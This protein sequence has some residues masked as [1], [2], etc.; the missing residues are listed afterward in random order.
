MPPGQGWS[1]DPWTPR[2]EGERLTGLGA[3]D[4]KGCVTAMIEAFLAVHRELKQGG[5]LGGTLV[6]ALTAQEETTG[7]G[8]PV[9]LDRL[10]PLDAAIVGEP[11]GLVPMTAQRGL[12]I[13]RGKAR[14]RTAHPA[15]TPPQVAENA[16]VAAAEDV[17][18]L[19][20]FDWGPAHPRLGRAHGNVTII[21]AGI[22]HNVIPDA[23]EFCLDIRTTPA[24]SHPALF[25]RLQAH[26]RSELSIQSGRLVAVRNAGR[27]RPIVRAACSASGNE[28]QGSATMS[29]MVFLTGIPA[30]KIGPGQSSRSHTPDE[31]ILE[32][33]LT[34]APRSTA[35]SSARISLCER[36]ERVS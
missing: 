4:A 31:F 18:R 29:D 33:E 36:T 2:R 20:E 1:G 3:N 30:V 21:K 12:L 24:E 28:P 10:R 25:A 6:L 11:T 14:G 13:L 22:A 34:E 32:S 17:L 35:G 19:R 9:I 27:L 5:K 26:L 8:L 16:I 15:N 7:E 23:C